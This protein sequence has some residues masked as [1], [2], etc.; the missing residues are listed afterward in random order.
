MTW[1]WLTA[2][3]AFAGVFPYEVQSTTL[4][5]GLEIHV[6]PMPSPGIV[7]Y[8][9]WMRVGSR[10]ELDEGRTGFAHFFEHL[11]FFGTETLG[12][13]DRER[14]ILAMGADEN[15]WTWVDETV[16][17]ATLSTAG[18]P[19]L[20][21]MEADRFA[22]LHLTPDDVEKESGAVYG[23]YRKGQAN[24][25]QRLAEVLSKTAFTAHSYRHDTIGYEADIKAM[26]SAHAY[27]QQFFNRHYRPENASILVVGDVTDEVVASIKSA[28]QGWERGA[29]RPQPTVEPEQVETLTAHVEWDQP[30]APRLVMA[31][32][33]PGHDPDDPEVAALELADNLLFGD[34]GPLTRRLVREE[35][36]AYAV[37][38]GREPFV[39]PCLFRVHVL[40]KEAGHRERTEVII[41]EELARL[42]SGVDDDRLRRTRDHA[43]YAFLTGLD[44][45][46]AVADALGWALRRG[47]TP[48]AIDRFYAVYDSVTSEALADTATRTFVDEHLTTVTLTHTPAEEE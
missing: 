27:S 4:D 28:Y 47:G 36:L 10:D 37:Y 6:V 9:T 40:L 24:P 25:S 46:P 18:L 48:D 45:P 16:Y 3:L 43:R 8:Y 32:K 15:A 35:G 7:S 12:G 11:M 13:E 31:W 5:N 29:E 44:S 21:E 19:G 30:T 34:T 17:T 26:P 33:I 42:S 39:D 23:E 20:I 14:A 41:R 38:G 22:N 1:I 2:T